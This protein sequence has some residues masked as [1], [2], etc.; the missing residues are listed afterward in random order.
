[1]QTTNSVFLVR[2]ANFGFNVETAVSNV[3][4]NKM[5]EKEEVIQSKVLK[6]F[7]VFTSTLR[8]KGVNV[9]VFDDTPTPVK[10]DAIFPN[11]WIS[12]HSNGKVILYPMCTP[13]RR[14]ER[15]QDIID[16]LAK[17]F[18]IAEV[19]DLS[20]SEADNKFME[21]TGSIVFDHTNRIAYACLS[22]RTDKDVFLKVCSILQ[23]KPVYFYSRDKSGKEIYHTNVVMCIGKG[24][25]VIC[26]ESITDKKERENV[27]EMLTGTGNQIIDISFEQMVSFAGNMLAIRSN[28]GKEL[29]VMSQTSYDSLTKNQRETLE[30][31]CEL[32]PLSINTIETIGGGSARCMIAEIFLQPIN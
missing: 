20:G 7:D 8:S 22:P 13:N 3:F 5:S 24:F 27:V 18:N 14:I 11:N 21:G 4:Q 26:L 2:P 16:S 9:F 30:K 31:Y 10:P 25:A 19:I 28:D 12:L 29:L 23:Y 17:K 6:E 32:V 15:R 1:M